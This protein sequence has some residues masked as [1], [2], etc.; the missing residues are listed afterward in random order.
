[1]YA[2]ADCVLEGGETSACVEREVEYGEGN[3]LRRQGRVPGT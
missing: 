3:G 2:C 1:M